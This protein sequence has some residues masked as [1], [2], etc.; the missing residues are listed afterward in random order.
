MVNDVYDAYAPPN[1]TLEVKEMETLMNEVQKMS[2]TELNIAHSA[3]K[4]GLKTDVVA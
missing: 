4:E 2:T 3:R 1:D